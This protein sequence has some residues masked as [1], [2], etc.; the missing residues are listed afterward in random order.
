MS[1][2]ESMVYDTTL[3]NGL[4]VIVVSNM[5]AP[6]VNITV[7]YKVGSKD[8]S[9][10]HKGFAHFFEHLMFDGSLN[11]GRGE[12]DSYCSKAGG[13]FNAYTSYDQTIYHSTF[14][15]H[16]LELA[17]WLESDRM[18]QFG[19]QQIGL[20]TQKKV[21]LE[22]MK[23]TVENQPYGKWRNI[24]AVC[25]FSKECSYNWE[26]LGLKE[27][28]E[29]ATLDEVARF[30]SMYYRPNNAYLVISGAVEPQ[31][32]IDLAHKYFGDIVSEKNPVMRHAFESSMQLSTSETVTDQVPLVAIFS[33][34]HF[35][36]F[37]HEDALIGDV[38]ASAA[39]DG[40]SSRLYTSLVRDKQIASSVFC[41]A[42]QR[43]HTSLLTFSATAAD[44]SIT[45]NQLRSALEEEIYTLIDHPF[46][47]H[48]LMKARNAAATGIAHHMQ[49]NS[50]LAD[51][52]CN[53]TMFWNNPKRAFTL[54]DKV[55][56]V[57]IE[58]LSIFSSS[59]LKEENKVGVS[60]IPG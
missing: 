6:V 7:G 44:P 51:L 4:R 22:E 9:F 21:V 14:P 58:D 40:R 28:I 8:D 39:A 41:F 59:V 45:E 31:K 53:Q 52:L 24:Q 19:V 29:S 60:I 18:L 32:G 43:E 26:I 3:H 15:A 46:E 30:F 1:S 56:A 23:Q 38:L 34:Y 16:Q 13:Q 2:I 35:P 12:F 42:D 55:S 5:K 10:K 27:H 50:G 20:D 11:V 57:T 54:L 17:L 48:E 25:A 47:H 37:L 36:G 33:S 49:T